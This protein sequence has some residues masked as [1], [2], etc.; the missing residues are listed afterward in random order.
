MG[1]W[2][3]FMVRSRVKRI[4]FCEF[5]FVVLMCFLPAAQADDLGWRG[6]LAKRASRAALLRQARRAEVGDPITSVQLPLATP[7]VSSALRLPPGVG[8]PADPVKVVSFADKAEVVEI[9]GNPKKAPQALQVFFANITTFGTKF[10]R[11]V[12]QVAPELGLHGLAL[13]E[14][15]L[16][17][18]ERV[19]RRRGC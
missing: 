1:S 12:R 7:A 9:A 4:L 5:A 15:H 14:H 11:W 13:A 18:G 6:P 19:F 16:P 17:Q 8:T 3:A 2:P 10:K